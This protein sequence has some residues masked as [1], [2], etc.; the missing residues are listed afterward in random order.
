[1]VDVMWLHV[2]LSVFGTNLKRKNANGF[3]YMSCGISPRHL[4]LS[5]NMYFSFSP[6]FLFCS[7]SLFKYSKKRTL[8][9]FF[10]SVI[11]CLFY[12]TV[13]LFPCLSFHPWNWQSPW[14]GN[15]TNLLKR[16]TKKRIQLLLI[17]TNFCQDT[18]L[19]RSFHVRGKITWK[20]CLSLKSD[21]SLRAFF[22]SY[23]FD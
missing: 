17:P 6:L 3:V 16:L 11:F 7:R 19:Q 20:L 23:T 21:Y 14:N 2:Q 5:L 18:G 10:P 4:S 15:N 8:L 13:C 12:S 1:M 22:S 9:F